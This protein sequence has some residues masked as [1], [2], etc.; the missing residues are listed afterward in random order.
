MKRKLTET[1]WHTNISQKP[2]RDRLIYTEIYRQTQRCRDTQRQAQTHIV[3][4]RHPGTNRP[5]SQKHTQWHT[6]IQVQIP[7]PPVSGTHPILSRPPISHPRSL[8][9]MCVQV[10]SEGPRA[11]LN[12]S[13]GEVGSLSNRGQARQWGE[14]W[15]AT[16]LNPWGWGRWFKLWEYQFYSPLIWG[17]TPLSGDC[18]GQ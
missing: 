12:H 6:H 14:G 11:G 16:V 1:Q 3:S 17:S 5:G 7:T 13:K 10:S 18:V 9:F 15:G 2:C 4:Q 8:V